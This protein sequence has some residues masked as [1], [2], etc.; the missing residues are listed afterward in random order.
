MLVAALL[1]DIVE[2]IHVTLEEVRI[3]FGDQVAQL[4]KLLSN[5]K[6]DTFKKY[7][8]SD[9]Q[10]HTERLAQN[11]DAILIKACDR[12]H[13]L[14]TLKAM[15]RAKQQAK[16]QETLDYYVPVVRAAGFTQLADLMKKMAKSYL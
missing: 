10:A 8:D 7:K 14:E 16:A 11:R 5:T 15:P 2:D 13:N 3:R 12:R 9:K 6:L 4:V 1:H